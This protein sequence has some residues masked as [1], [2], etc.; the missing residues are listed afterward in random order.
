LFSEAEYIQRKE[1]YEKFLWKCTVCNSEFRSQYANGIEPRCPICYPPLNGFSIAEREISEYIR[2]KNIEVI[3]NSYKIIPP[4]E[5]DIYV[6]SKNLAIEF[7]GTYWHSSDRK[8]NKW[9]HQYKVEKCNRIGI[10]LL[11]VFEWEWENNKQECLNK[12]DYYLNNNNEK[13]KIQFPIARFVQCGVEKNYQE[14]IKNKKYFTI[15]H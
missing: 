12:I 9:Y 8:I 6:P 14:L 5:I 1:K 7:N 10:R 3:E 2:F 15:F 11:H 13:I 4:Q